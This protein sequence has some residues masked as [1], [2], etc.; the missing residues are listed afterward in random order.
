MTPTKTADPETR[1]PSIPPSVTHFG[2]NSV[3]TAVALAALFGLR[4]H[5]IGLENDV[6][7]LF[8]AAAV[9]VIA[10]DV[11]FLRVHRRATTGLDWSREFSPSAGRVG[12][13]LVGLAVV[14]GTIAL[15][16]WAF[17]EYHGSFYD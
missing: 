5:D 7:V 9:P 14:I 11:L 10:F 12:T 17:P 6:L 1:R 16:Y 13:K 3:A 15:A 2:L 8:A 4:Q